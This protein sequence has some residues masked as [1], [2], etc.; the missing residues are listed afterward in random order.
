M[1]N[2]DTSRLIT[3]AHKQEQAQLALTGTFELAIQASL[4]AAAK[5]RGYDSIATAVS[6]AEEPAVPRFQDDGRAFRAWRSLVWAYAY[7]ELAK[8]KAGERDVPTLDAFMA[9]L[10]VLPDLAT[11]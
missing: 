11:V 9:E 5:A 7:E 8:V 6:Y 3:K 1:G 2:I 4:D 10:P